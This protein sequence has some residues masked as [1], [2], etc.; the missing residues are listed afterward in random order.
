MH[1]LDKSLLWVTRIGVFFV[2]F[3]PLIIASSLF[4]PFITGKGFAFRV[5]VEIVFACYLLLALRRPEFRP[6][7]SLILYGVLAFITVVFLADAFAIN[8]FKAFWSNFERMEGFV[9]MI[10]LVAYFFVASAVLNS[11]KWWHRFFATS[12]G[13]S[14]FLGIYGVLQLLGK[15][16]INQGGVRLDGTF[17]N[18]AYFAGYMLFHIFLS[19]FLMLRHRIPPMYTW[20]YG[21]AIALQVFTLI[22]TATRGAALGL[23]GGLA[24]SFLLIIL[25][26][27]SNRRLRMGAVGAFL[28]LIIVVVGLYAGRDVSFIKN[29]PA[30]TRFA[31]VSA[32]DAGPRLMVWGMAWQGFKEHPVLGWGQEGF[33]YVFNKYYNPDMW[34]Q[35]QWF[36]RTH[37]IFFDWLI[38][39]GALGLL[40]Y[41]SLFAFLLWYIWRGEP[42]DRGDSFSFAEKSI[43]SGLL[44]GYGIHNFFVFD[45]LISYI[46][47]FSL[48]AYVHTRFGKP[49]PVFEK[50]APIESEQTTSIVGAALLVLLCFGIYYLNL[51]P[52]GVA[53]DLIQALRP[54]QKGITEN[55]SFYKQA[56]AV[57]SVGTQ[58]VGEQ[59]IQAAANVAA[60]SNVPEPVKAEFVSF[61]LSA[62]GREITRAP[63]DARL[64]MFIGG[65]LNQL[66][67]YTEALPHLEKAHQ[68]SQSKQ[69]IAFSL[70]NTYLSLGKTAE[71]LPLMKVAFESAPNNT[72]ARIAYAATAIY[73]G[74]LTTA[75][76]IL[77]STTEVSVLT[78]ERLVKAYFQA[79]QLKKVIS[80]LQLRV[81]ADPTN[82][83]TH[84]S[85]AA[86][87]SASGNR[88]QSI[89]EL[90]KAIELN[91]DFKKQGEYYI[92][93]IQ[94]GRNP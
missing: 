83:Q 49:F 59:A 65:F 89:V 13:V 26:E 84:I 32:S 15:I 37:D 45:N 72:G 34:T 57:E 35:E 60:A 94:A 77:A 53:G 18:S 20:M 76:E 73:A 52:L 24:L 2:P 7:R 51:R 67:H 33:N 10:H 70:S 36:D 23:V 39:A 55:L 58:E 80:L 5:I 48:L 29:S 81:S 91:P 38:S 27:K 79:K 8:P 64:R 88:A 19:L 62:M 90:Q 61:A 82:A 30:L 21:A 86:A 3:V 46:L 87:Y 9:T 92:G 78:D 44:A 66:G 25:F 50:R 12:V 56:F 42:S 74:N 14:A 93:E 54:Q 4:F 75:D 1:T 43:L 31:S 40:A 17:G 11:E 71:A 22:F 41:L 63:D 69:T 28:A 6:K 16:V 85:L 47:F 68:L